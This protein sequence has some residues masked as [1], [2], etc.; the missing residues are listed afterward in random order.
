[1]DS[2]RRAFLKCKI[3]YVNYDDRNRKPIVL[4]CGHTICQVC[5]GE[6]S[7]RAKTTK[8]I[9]C[10][11]DQKNY[12]SSKVSTNY[13]LVEAIGQEESSEGNLFL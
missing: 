1:M 9:T 11:F 8:K 6:M 13:S 2:K 5:F 3:C 10:P 7:Q 12:D 4:P